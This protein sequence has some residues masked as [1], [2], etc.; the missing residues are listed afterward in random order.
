MTEIHSGAKQIIDYLDRIDS[1]WLY[2]PIGTTWPQG[3]VDAL[4]E[5][6]GEYAQKIGDVLYI[7]HLSKKRGDDFAKVLASLK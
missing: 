3:T 6:Y 2:L 5:Y 7:N 1:E 4:L